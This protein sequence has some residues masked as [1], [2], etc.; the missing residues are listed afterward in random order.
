M[1]EPEPFV[2]L[3]NT[4]LTYE[5]ESCNLAT[6]ITMMTDGTGNLGQMTPHISP[7]FVQ[8]G[9][10]II[11][12]PTFATNRSFV[13]QQ[14]S[15]SQKAWECSCLLSSGTSPEFKDCEIHGASSSM[16]VSHLLCSRP[17]T[18]S[19]GWSSLFI[20]MQTALSFIPT[21]LAYCGHASSSNVDTVRTVV[22]PVTL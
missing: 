6:P 15:K 12:E 16:L 22:I 8:V 7:A 4:L 9:Q 11:R 13:R 20:K 10:S 17:S 14:P 1:Q 19:V 2:I 18:V 3:C 21:F 5:H